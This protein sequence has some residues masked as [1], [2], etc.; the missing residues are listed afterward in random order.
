MSFSKRLR[1]LREFALIEAIVQVIGYADWTRTKIANWQLEIEDLR[2]VKLEDWKIEDL[3]DY[4][5]LEF[6]YYL[7]LVPPIGGTD[8]VLAWCQRVQLTQTQTWQART[9]T[10]AAQLQ[11]WLMYSILESKRAA[12]Q[13]VDSDLFEQALKFA[14]VPQMV[15][16]KEKGLR[17]RQ[18][19]LL[20]EK[21]LSAQ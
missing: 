17:T 15:L 10:Q 2:I 19:V 1:V 6:G 14:V 3:F 18:I 20:K 8:L 12:L 13:K 4:C 21:E 5:F 16:L 11:I 7:E 9:Q